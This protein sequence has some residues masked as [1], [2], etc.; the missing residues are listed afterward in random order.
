MVEMGAYQRGE[1][2]ELCR[3]TGPSDIGILCGINEQHLERF[4]GIEN[5]IGRNTS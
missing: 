5:T 4:G 1:I 2:A 3:L